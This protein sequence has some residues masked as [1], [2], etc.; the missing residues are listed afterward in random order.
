MREDLREGNAQIRHPPCQAQEQQRQCCA[1][2]LVA[3][4]S[5]GILTAKGATRKTL[6]PD[7]RA[8][9]QFD[10]RRLAISLTDQQSARPAAIAGVIP[11]P[12]VQWGRA[13]L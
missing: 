13:T 4:M 3:L 10:S 12:S 1:K 9:G 11:R 8:V 6:D 5:R 2:R 7:G